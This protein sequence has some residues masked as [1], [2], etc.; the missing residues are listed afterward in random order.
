L[1]IADLNHYLLRANDLDA[2]K[3][4][5]IDVLGFTV[6]PR[7]DLPFPGYWLGIGDK[8]LVHIAQHGVERADVYYL[9]TP[10]DAATDHSGV[11]DH[12]AFVA[13]DPQGMAAHFDRL[14]VRY[15]RRY[16]PDSALYQLFVTDPNGLI[17]ELNFFGIA[18]VSGW[19]GDPGENYATMPRS[20]ASR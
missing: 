3:A 12:I 14:G 13:T 8:T 1:P 20:G 16:L 11:I 10:A 7:P 6:M 17:I 5:Y 4:F 2:T 18:D 19:S 15:R 9:G